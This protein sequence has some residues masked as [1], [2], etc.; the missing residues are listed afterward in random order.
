MES[1]Q[2]NRSVIAEATRSTIA[3]YRRAREGSLEAVGLFRGFIDIA[4]E[5]GRW[6]G[7]GRSR[8]ITDNGAVILEFERGG[9]RV[10]QGGDLAVD[11]AQDMAYSRWVESFMADVA[12]MERAEFD[13]LRTFIYRG[14]SRER[15]AELRHHGR[16]ARDEQVRIWQ[17]RQA[18]EDEDIR[19][20]EDEARVER[21]ERVR[22]LDSLHRAEQHLA[23]YKNTVKVITEEAAVAKELLEKAQRELTEAKQSQEEAQRE[24]VE[25]NQSLERELAKYKK[26]LEEAESKMAREKA[27][28]ELE[29]ESHRAGKDDRENTKDAERADNNGNDADQDGDSEIRGKKPG[30]GRGLRFK[31]TGQP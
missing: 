31:T 15:L 7:Y 28:R 19:L 26:L 14:F 27:Q 9:R 18:R 12:G 5:I 29:E 3:G 25:S 10:T 16:T 1:S 8:C 20:R 21:I 4:N 24:A 30:C 2:A 23:D 13:Q 22:R 17:E 6:M 11:R